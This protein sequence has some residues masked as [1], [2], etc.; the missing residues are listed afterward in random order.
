MDHCCCDDGLVPQED[1]ELQQ[2]QLEMEG[3]GSEEEEAAE[4]M[5]EDGRMPGTDLALYGGWRGQGSRGVQP[6]AGASLGASPWP[7]PPLARCSPLRRGLRH[8]GAGEDGGGMA[9]VLH[10]DKKY[11]PTAE[12][13]YGKET[14]ALVQEEDAQP[15]EVPII[16]PIKQKKFQVEES[17]G[18]RS[19][20]TPEFLGSLLST[21]ELI[22]S[23]AVVGHLHHGKTL[24]RRSAGVRKRGGEAG[25]HPAGNLPLLHRPCCTIIPTPVLWPSLLRPTTTPQLMDMFV[26][27]TH[28]LTASQRSNERPMRYTDTRVDEQARAIS[29][30]SVPMS[31][32]MEGSSGKSYAIN[33]IDTPGE[34]WGR[35]PLRCGSSWPGCGAGLQV[36]AGGCAGHT[37]IPDFV[38]SPHCCA[39]SCTL[40][41]PAPADPPVPLSPRRNRPQATSTSLTSCRRRCACLTACCWW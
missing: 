25:R 39:A 26:E 12:E 2:Q 37:T 40:H 27:Q 9:V 7:L 5:D 24:V 1:E 6:P 33:L 11:Y 21:P 13:T 16:A 30:K 32:V 3:P 29:L 20:Y 36:W 14:E 23:V 31:L 17:Q 19:R 18:L 35:P 8:A 34:A 4:A 41:P 15:L 28:E 38:A 22:R 10:E